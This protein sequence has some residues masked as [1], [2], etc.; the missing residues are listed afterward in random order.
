LLENVPCNTDQ[1]NPCGNIW[2]VPDWSKRPFETRKN[3]AKPQFSLETHGT[4]L[5]STRY[6]LSRASLVS[7]SACQQA[8]VT[9]TRAGSE[10]SAS[11][12][13][14]QAC[15]NKHVRALLEYCASLPAYPALPDRTSWQTHPTWCDRPRIVPL[16]NVHWWPKSSYLPEGR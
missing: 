3:Q 13:D 10:R 16:Y 12:P 5:N 15:A 9:P 1:R 7:M 11:M 2:T 4:L 8:H 6:S 14:T